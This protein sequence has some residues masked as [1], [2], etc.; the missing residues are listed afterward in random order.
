[1]GLESLQFFSWQEVLFV[2]GRHQPKKDMG[3]CDMCLMQYVSLSVHFFAAF[4]GINMV[5]ILLSQVSGWVIC[6][7]AALASHL[8]MV[9][10]IASLVRDASGALVGKYDTSYR[11]WEG[12]VVVAWLLK[13]D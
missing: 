11:H 2:P 8:Y 5:I 12:R 1:M 10:Q 9:N 7:A 13:M 6:H 3:I 4:F